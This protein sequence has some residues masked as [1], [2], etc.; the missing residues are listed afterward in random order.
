MGEVGAGCLVT[1]GPFFHS[2]PAPWES[3]EQRDVE[4]GRKGRDPNSFLSL[5]SDETDD[6]IP[7]ISP[8]D[9]PS[10]NGPYRSTVKREPSTL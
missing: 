1:S 10:T 6:Q 9:I 3:Q 5:N 7:G 2:H 4:V 8:G